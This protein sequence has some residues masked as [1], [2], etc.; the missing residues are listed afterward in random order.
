VEDALSKNLIRSFFVHIT[1]HGLLDEVCSRFAHL[2]ECPFE[3]QRVFFEYA[4]GALTLNSVMQTL[5]KICSHPQQSG[6]R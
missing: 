3:G 4:C 5:A 2:C 6:P 1:K